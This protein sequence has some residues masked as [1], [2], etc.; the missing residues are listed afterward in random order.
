M[1]ALSLIPRATGLNAS[2]P[3]PGVVRQ[4]AG[5]Q[6]AHVRLRL[7]VEP[8]RL[9]GGPAQPALAVVEQGV[10]RIRMARTPDPPEEAPGEVGK[11]GECPSVGKR[12]ARRPKASDQARRALGEGA[13]V[14]IRRISPPFIPV[15]EGRPTCYA[16]NGSASTLAARAQVEFRRRVQLATPGPES[17]PHSRP[18]KI[19]LPGPAAHGIAAVNRERPVSPAA[20]VR[21]GRKR[22]G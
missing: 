20:G 11:H 22:Q 8:A 18:R 19:E 7:E 6:R 14:S 1:G 15:A 10:R 9:L 5:V 13:A 17:F 16:S 4:V 3:R 21:L 12:R 2:K